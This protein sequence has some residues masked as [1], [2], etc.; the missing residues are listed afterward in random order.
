VRVY[1]ASGSVTDVIGDTSLLPLTA[2]PG[3]DFT[4]EFTYDDAEADLAPDDAESGTYPGLAYAV[5]IAGRTLEHANELEGA[6]AI[7][8]QLRE[9]F[10]LWGASA[11]PATS[12]TTTRRASTSTST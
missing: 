10:D 6:S 3:D 12:R 7:Q 4:I 5:T 9:T 8:I 11:T 1:R 2:A